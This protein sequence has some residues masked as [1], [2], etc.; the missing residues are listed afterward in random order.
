MM[1]T[2]GFEEVVT[3]AWVMGSGKPKFGYKDAVVQMFEEVASG[4]NAARFLGTL[5]AC[6]RTFKPPQG[7][8]A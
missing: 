6:G 4:S 8:A 1:G 7:G 3:V 5:G 2:K